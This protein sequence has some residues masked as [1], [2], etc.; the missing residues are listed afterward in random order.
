ME[1]E[2]EAKVTEGGNNLSVGTKQVCYY[3]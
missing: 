3:W 2:L 1:G